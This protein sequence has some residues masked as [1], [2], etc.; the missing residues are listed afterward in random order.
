MQLGYSNCNSKFI[1]AR[2]TKESNTREGGYW[3]GGLTRE[4]LLIT[5]FDK[6]M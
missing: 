4:W 5:F 3:R 2:T 6:N 1:T